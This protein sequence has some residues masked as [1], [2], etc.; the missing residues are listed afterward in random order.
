[1][2]APHPAAGHGRNAEMDANFVP[3][4]QPS[5]RDEF[6]NVDLGMLFATG[7]ARGLK[8]LDR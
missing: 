6:R 8:S 1:M 2:A 3:S 7:A 4:L 5:A